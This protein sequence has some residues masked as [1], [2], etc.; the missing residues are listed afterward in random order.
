MNPHMYLSTHTQKKNNTRLAVR[1]IAS[2]W[3]C[4]CRDWSL[5]KL[6]VTE[7]SLVKGCAPRW[8]VRR[9]Y[10]RV[11][12]SGFLDT[13]LLISVPSCM[14]PLLQSYRYS[15]GTCSA[16][17]AA[18]QSS[19]QQELRASVGFSGKLSVQVHILWV[20]S[21]RHRFSHLSTPP[22]SLSPKHAFPYK[23]C[24]R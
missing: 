22:L 1:A 6:A 19:Q 5:R 23:I 13:L 21:R 15:R 10:Q 17:T 7:T 8:A 14:L 16:F 3:T 24:S 2:Q 12:G 4:H 20:S 9:R 18:S 11:S